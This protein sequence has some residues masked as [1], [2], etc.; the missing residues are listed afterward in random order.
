MELQN[1]LILGIIGLAAGLLG[2]MLGLG[3]AIIIIPALM[4]FLGYSQQLAQ[5]TALIMMVLPVGALA[6]FQYYQKGFVDVKAALILAGFFFVGGF[7]GA[8]FATQ[9]PQEILK[10]VFAVMLVGIAL[11]MWFQK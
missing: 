1:A 8:K 7:F 11:K 10:K 5:G 9:I 4:I 3:G 2:G 6:A